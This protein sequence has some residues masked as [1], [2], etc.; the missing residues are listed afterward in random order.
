MGAVYTVILGSFLSTNSVSFVEPRKIRKNRFESA[1]L[2]LPLLPLLPLRRP[3]CLLSSVSTFSSHLYSHLLPL[4]F[5]SSSFIPVHKG[6]S[7]DISGG[8]KIGTYR[9]PSCNARKSFN[10]S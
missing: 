1:K 4:T 8:I 6:L 2:F 9:S 10:V 7:G 3:L 5:R